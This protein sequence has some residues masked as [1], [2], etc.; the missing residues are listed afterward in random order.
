MNPQRTLNSI[1]LNLQVADRLH[2]YV[3][4]GDTVK[5][6]MLISEIVLVDWHASA[7]HCRMKCILD[8]SL[9]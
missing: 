9:S 2:W 8:F 3:K 4:D 1:T 5:N 6:C 7:L